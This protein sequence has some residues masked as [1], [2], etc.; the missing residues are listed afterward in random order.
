[1]Q[2]GDQLFFGVVLDVEREARL[3]ELDLVQDVHEQNAQ[4]QRHQRGVERDTETVRDGRRVTF[5]GELGALQCEADTADGTD[6]SERGSDPD[7]E[8]QYRELGVEAVVL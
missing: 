8:S 4:R 1:M 5:D 2:A 7:A 6:E 3:R